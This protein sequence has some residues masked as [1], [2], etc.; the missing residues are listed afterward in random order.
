MAKN[1]YRFWRD[2]FGN[3]LGLM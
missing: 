1:V 2:Y 3:I